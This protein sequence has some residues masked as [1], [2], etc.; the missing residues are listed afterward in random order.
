[1]A[2]NPFNIFRRNQ[3]ALFAVLTV[4]IMIMFTLSF[5]ANDF[6]ER[7]A[8]WVGKSKGESICKIDG[9][10]IKDSDLS[11]VRRG[12]VMANTFMTHAASYTTLTVK[13]YA[14][15]QQSKLSEDGKQMAGVANQAETWLTNPQFLNNPM[16]GNRPRQ[17]IA[18]ADQ[19]VKFMLEN[20]N[21]KSEDRD[22]A[23]AY[24]ALLELRARRLSS[25]GEH[26]FLNAPNK[27]NRDTIEFLLWEKKADQLGINY[28]PDDVLVLLNR[29]FYNFWSARS[30][31]EVQKDL[32]GREGFN[33]D[34]CLKALAVEFKV[35]AAQMAVLGRVDNIRRVGSPAFGTPYEMFEYYRE[36]CS[37]AT[38]ELVAVP[39]SAFTDKVVGEP[40]EAELNEFYKKY[41]EEEPNPSK[42]TPGFKEP[43]KLS[44]SWLAIT[45]EE[46]YYQ[47]LAA[48]QVKV[49]EVMAKASGMTA[50][51]LPGT[52]GGWAM[53]AAAPLAIKE[54]AVDAAYSRYKDL[55]EFTQQVKYERSD[56]GTSDLLPTSAVRP[57]T[58]AALL[59]GM[60]GQS[61]PFGHPGVAASLAMGAP[62]AY[63]IRDRVKIGLPLALGLLPNPS[64][65]ETIVG[66]A[67][68]SKANEPKALPVEAVRP[69]LIKTTVKERV[70]MLVH[71]T[72]PSNRVTPNDEKGDLAKFM[73]EMEKL[74]EKG[75][76]KDKAA[77]EKYAKEF[78]AARGLTKKGEQ[79]DSTTA[80]RDEWNIEE[81]PGLRL[82]VE[83]Q[84]DS[85]GRAR[86]AH[87]GKQYIPFGRSFFWTTQADAAT[88][89]MRRVATAGVYLARP[90]P[91]EDR[92]AP[93]EE[94]R[95]TY[96]Y[97]VTEDLAPK[98]TNLITSKDAVRAAWKQMKAR[99]LAAARANAMAEAIRNSTANDPFLL[100]QVVA[101]EAYKFQTEI[102]ITNRKA[103]A[104]VKPF[105]IN[106]VCPLAP[107][108]LTDR[109]PFQPN[110]SP[111]GR[112]QEFRLSESDNIPYRT[113]EMEKALLDNRDKPS[114]TVFV[115]A[116][117]PK[118]TYYV[119]T[120]LSGRMR[121]PEDFKQFVYSPAGPAHNVITQLY[122][123]DTA[124]KAYKSVIELLKK[125]FKYA[126]TEE[127]KKKL[128]ENAKSG[129]RD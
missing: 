64:M 51:P 111:F 47:K 34:T 84:R 66:G 39:A 62:I 9:D 63:E 121:T 38:Y 10:T 58:M 68:A 33:M 56:I 108:D 19:F 76:P 107:A 114:K 120:L 100:P 57:G 32:R 105:T 26:F 59:G 77:V 52:G 116:D 83:A 24:R 99:E 27:S 36:Q 55:F 122:Q 40:T 14:N 94:G 53:A 2:Y 23:R 95:P 128:D 30:S 8:K 22:A 29:E 17:D 3:K 73:E 74:S 110:A 104:R 21:T 4:F 50:V 61:G 97:W 65:I 35:R 125:E 81:D 70:K 86:G 113:D 112:V 82:L 88:F 89:S 101:D 16:F 72:P 45:G 85:L 18:D 106:D 92:G 93:R 67:A 1:M 78:M 7:A 6:F 44:I 80:P 15:Q 117:A 31:V 90:F 75:K 12:R 60:A 124:V 13:E 98:K 48:E 42:E 49:G 129:G 115:M 20:P 41:Q 28:T 69:E 46:P 11:R 103:L 126:E 123:R 25:D 109:D 91:P 102:A 87:G 37:P 118:D 54:P 71:G 96:V 119:A 43:R 127:Q 5:G 79:F